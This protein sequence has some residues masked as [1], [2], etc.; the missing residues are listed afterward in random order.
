MD[1]D[2]AIGETGEVSPARSIWFVIGLLLVVGGYAADTVF[3]PRARRADQDCLE[4]VA[5][6]RNRLS[7]AQARQDSDA[8]MQAEMATI[9][10]APVFR[11]L[12]TRR[13]HYA[14]LNRWMGFAMTGGL[15][16]TLPM[17]AVWALRRF[18]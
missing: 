5:Q 16:I 13:L 12:M 14:A 15:G 3:M 8:V 4:M 2:P 7:D 18:F 9:H 17:T 6:Q 10:E 1:S 11:Q